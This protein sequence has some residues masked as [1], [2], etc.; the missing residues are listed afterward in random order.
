MTMESEKKEKKNKK[1]IEKSR[2]RILNAR[3]CGPLSFG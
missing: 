2:K 3:L 1:N